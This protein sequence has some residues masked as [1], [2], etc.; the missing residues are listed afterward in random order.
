MVSLLILLILFHRRTIFKTL[1]LEH[2]AEKGHFI[3]GEGSSDCSNPPWLWACLLWNLYLRQWLSPPA[4]PWVTSLWGFVLMVVC[5]HWVLYAL[6]CVEL[7]DDT[8]VCYLQKYCCVRH[9][10]ITWVYLSR[11]TCTTQ[12]IYR[13]SLGVTV[14]P[15]YG[16]GQDIT[17]TMSE[18]EKERLEYIANSKQQVY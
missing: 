10:Y 14:T 15:L 7:A 4:F 11:G 8:T 16:R 9:H 2:S 1:A 3:T 12:Q 17:T 13:Y 18:L 6:Y 5:T